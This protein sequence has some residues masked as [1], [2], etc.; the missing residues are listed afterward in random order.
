M[1]IFQDLAAAHCQTAESADVLLSSPDSE[2]L[3]S[4]L[5]GWTLGA[6][7]DIEKAYTFP[8]FLSALAFV[9]AIGGIA[10]EQGHHP[11]LYLGWGKVKVG[12]T[13]H[14]AGGLTR[15]DFIVAAKIE[16]YAQRSLP[17]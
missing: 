4:A 1:S 12:L 16:Q 5:D 6:G 14:D 2:G 10:E 7:K 8:D 13:T 15:A 11:D 17:E 9:N 3:L